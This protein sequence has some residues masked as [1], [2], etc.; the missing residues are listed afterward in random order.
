MRRR[1]VDWAR[2]LAILVMVEAHTL[3]AWTRTSLRTSHAFRHLTVLGGFAAPLFLWLA[4]MALVLSA[5]RRAERTGSPRQAT[6]FVCRRGLEVFVLAFLFRLQAFIVSPGSWLVTIFRVDILNVMGPAMVVAGLVWGAARGA[7]SR[8]VAF[9]VLTAITA[10]A[11]PLVRA[12]AWVNALPLWVGWYFRPMGDNTTFTLFPWVAFLF[13]GGAAGAIVV[14]ARD[15]ADERRAQI[16]FAVA[17]VVLVAAG[18]AAAARPALYAETSFWTTSP[19]FFAIRLGTLMTALPLLYAGERMLTRRGV[20]LT[21][22][23]K[24]GRSS[25]FVYWIHVELV[26]G[27]ATWP[28]HG[29]L[30]L[31]ELAIAY[32]V[33]TCTLYG[34]ILLRDKVVAGWRSRREAPTPM[35]AATA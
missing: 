24:F 14:A 30:N 3:D 2:A 29:H 18:F 8:A 15:A 1:Y 17:G 6:A 26:Y 20:V 10:M 31:W 4:G 34:A 16:A 33:F 21:R 11:T 27:Y 19:A 22:L 13:G 12:S 5:E 23:E 9:S 35:T 28:I 7:R 25:L 32:A